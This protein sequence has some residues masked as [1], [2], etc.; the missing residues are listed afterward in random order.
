MSGFSTEW[1]ALREPLDARSRAH[2]LVD[3]L[4]DWR[5]SARPIRVLDLGAGTGANLRYLA[6]RLRGTQDW[7]LTDNDPAL[8]SALPRVMRAWVDAEGWEVAERPHGLSVRSC[9]FSA[10]ILSHRCD[11]AADLGRL[12]I[13]NRDLVT[14]SALLDLVSGDW[15]EALAAGCRRKRAAALLA[16]TYDG[17][18]GFDPQ[19]PEDAEV[20]A[21]VNRHQLTDKGFGPALGP[22][23]ANAAAFLFASLGYRVHTRRSDWQ[24]DRGQAEIQRVLIAGWTTAAT[25][26]APHRSAGLE[27]WRRRRLAHVAAS[28]ARLR[29]GHVDLLALPEP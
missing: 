28:R 4:G 9:A 15:L 14:T 18:M 24:M 1:L 5:E 26:M 2:D 13:G 8:L 29:V 10:G 17:R 20:T 19:E 3:A 25:E 12:P 6:P 21:L 7:L 22:G 27:D 16:L 11:L 23:A